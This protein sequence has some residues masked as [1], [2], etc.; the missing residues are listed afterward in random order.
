MN[1]NFPADGISDGRSTRDERSSEAL[2][3]L[4]D[5]S[6]IASFR[7]VLTRYT[8]FPAPLVYPSVVFSV[9]RSLVFLFCGGFCFGLTFL[10]YPLEPSPLKEEIMRAV[11]KLASR[12]APGPDDMAA[13]LLRFGGEMT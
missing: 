1:D 7:V 10:F 13:E 2:H 4:E 5:W 11:M 6:A 3:C 8:M 9:P 12:K